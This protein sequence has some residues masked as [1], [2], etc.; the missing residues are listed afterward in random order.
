L[1]TDIRSMSTA[2]SR[3]VSE[4][5]DIHGKC[6]SRDELSG[7]KHERADDP[8]TLRDQRVRFTAA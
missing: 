7:M 5:A 2:G 3:P 1:S 6:T 8:A 4:Q